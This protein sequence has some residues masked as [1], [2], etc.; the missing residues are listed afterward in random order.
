MRYGAKAAL[1]DAHVMAGLDV[2]LLEVHLRADDLPGR[3]ESIVSTFN[4]IRSESGL[5]LVVHAPEFMPSPGEPFLVDLA[6]PDGS[7]RDMAVASVQMAIELARDIDARLIVAHPGGILA[8]PDET[9]AEGGIQRLLTSLG[10]LR[11][12][13]REAG[14][15]LT[16][17]NMPWFYNRKMMDGSMEQWESTILV[18]PEDLEALSGSLDGLTLD[19]SHGYLH[20]SQGGM[21]AI[22][23]FVERYGGLVKHLHLSDAL[24]PDH[25]GLQIGEG[26]VDFRYVLSSFGRRDVTAVPEI[27]GG[28]RSGGLPFKRA[29]EELRG[30][31]E[32]L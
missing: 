4:G 17:E 19:V 24:P 18:E 10:P 9:V 20:C 5:D 31:Q 1:S 11:D 8:R 30:I 13:A 26:A 21:E 12:G 27:I 23:S 3:R 6:S 28:H 32:G 29:L 2:E 7:L 14:V 25:E 22:R 16:L 15:V